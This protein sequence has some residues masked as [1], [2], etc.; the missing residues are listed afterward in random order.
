MPSEG[1]QRSEIAG[2]RED[3]EA[4]I[5]DAARRFREIETVAAMRLRQ[6]TTERQHLE[7]FLDELQMRVRTITQS[8]ELPVMIT[9][10]LTED[11]LH[12]MQGQQENLQQ[13]KEELATISGDLDQ[14]SNRIG[15]LVHQIE[16]AGEWVLKPPEHEGDGD[17]NAPQKETQPNSGDQMMWAQIAM[18]QEAE[19]ARLAREI[20][21]G[22]AQVIANTVMRLQF[23]EQMAKHRPAEVGTELV[24]L[25][26]TLQESLK[27]VRRFM[28]NL[29]PASLS[30]AGLIATL[31]YYTQDYS[32]QRELPV[33][34]NVPE[35]LVLSSNQELV[36]FRVV[37]ESL[38]NIYKHAEASEVKIDVQ[39]RPG[40]PLTVTIA[41]DGRG[42]DTKRSRQGRTGSSGLVNMRE[43]AATVG[44][45]LKVESKPGSGTIV[46]L[47]LPMPKYS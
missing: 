4:A 37:Q 30:D 47:V 28:F 33:E 22:P 13:H 44:G 38:Q 8:G 29:R 34:L 43:R 14:L 11:Q 40:G 15:W 42:F 6:A 10:P 12:A 18:G 9:G 16:G 41:D 35:N 23:V 45:T 31:R 17:G 46:T 2:L 27:E 26:A 19:R 3:V 1:V 7:A 20:H 21:D 32:E 25:R 5:A 24:K 39:Q 36:V